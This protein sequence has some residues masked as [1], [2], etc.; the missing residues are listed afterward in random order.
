MAS[1][2]AASVIVVVGMLCLYWSTAA[3]P[4]DVGSTNMKVGV[5]A[6]SNLDP[7]RHRHDGAQ[8]ITQWDGNRVGV[9]DERDAALVK[10]VNHHTGH[11]PP[12]PPAM[13]VQSHS[14]APLD[15]T[16]IG[17]WNFRSDPSLR[18]DLSSIWSTPGAHTGVAVSQVRGR[19]EPV[20][21]MLDSAIHSVA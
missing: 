12:Q 8:P 5:P 14:H 4:A 2:E 21:S 1:S 7:T 18:K 15:E 11:T 17:G 20:H 9:H 13:T 16:I 19:S 3:S 6:V 10:W